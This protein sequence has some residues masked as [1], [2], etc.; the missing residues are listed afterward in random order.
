MPV[1][2]DGVS[3]RTRRANENNIAGVEQAGR[4]YILRWRE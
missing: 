3:Q 4:D 2:I 1:Q